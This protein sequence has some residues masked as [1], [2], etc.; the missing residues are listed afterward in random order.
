M[1]VHDRIEDSQLDCATK[2]QLLLAGK[3][4]AYLE[5]SCDRQSSWFYKGSGQGP[6]HHHSLTYYRDLKFTVLQVKALPYET[7]PHDFTGAVVRA[8]QI[9]VSTQ[10]LI[11]GKLRA[12]CSHVKRTILTKTTRFY[13]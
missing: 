6:A 13:S 9:E 7:L 3:I 2:L 5:L 8:A 11:R 4:E 12:K 1:E 10:W